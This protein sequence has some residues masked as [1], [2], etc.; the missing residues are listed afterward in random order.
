MS[1]MDRFRP[2]IFVIVFAALAAF[3]SLAPA[4]DKTPVRRVGLTQINH[5]LLVTFSFRDAFP[6]SIQNQLSSGLKTGILIQLT[7]ERQGSTT[8]FAY[9]A[10]TVEITYDLWEDK[11]LVLREDNTGRRRA[12]VASKQKAVDLAAELSHIRLIDTE[13]LP[14]G[15]YRLR[16]KIETNPVSKEMLEK[17]RSWLVK[18]QTKSTANATPTNYFGSFVGA[19]VDRRIGEA[20]H[21]IDFVSQWF[22]LGEP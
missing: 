13:N 15:V 1:Q 17:I 22:S 14:P 19:L 2:T 5:E 8:P 10:G 12:S 6:Q 11:Y 18:S 3:S 4:D 7:L 9:W 20:D 21:T 16:A